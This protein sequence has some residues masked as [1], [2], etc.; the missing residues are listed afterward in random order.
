MEAQSTTQPTSDPTTNNQQLKT[1]ISRNWT[2][3]WIARVAETEARLGHPICGSRTIAGRPCELHPNHPN[4]RCRFHGG[5]DLTGAPKGNRNAMIHGLYSRRLRTCSP[6]CPQWNKCPAAGPDV[7]QLAPVDQPTCPFEQT[8]YNSAVTDALSM[9]ASAPFRHD[10]MHHMAHNMALLQVMLGRAAISIRNNDVVD[11]PQLP[12][13]DIQRP[14]APR[15]RPSARLQA[16]LRIQSEL[17]RT[18]HLLVP[19]DPVNT[20]AFDQSTRYKRSI[21]DGDT[22]IES[23]AQRDLWDYVPPDKYTTALYKC[24][25]AHYFASVDHQN[26]INHITEAC[27]LSKQ[28]CC[29]R[30]AE[31]IAAYKPHKNGMTQQQFTQKIHELLPP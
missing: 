8:E 28:A 4:G 25:Q 16:F 22:T 26:A 29:E 2:D 1:V 3:D 5:F 6:E 18:L 27:K 9:L 21:L 10:F 30:K 31:I 12:P 13:D 24:S 19:K 20:S 11:E 7:A 23:N 14:N 15:P 17:R